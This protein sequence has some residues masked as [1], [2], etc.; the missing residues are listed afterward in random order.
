MALTIGG[1]KNAI[2]GNAIFNATNTFCILFM[3]K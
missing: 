2:N 3:I 1:K